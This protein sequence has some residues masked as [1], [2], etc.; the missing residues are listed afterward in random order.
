V[1]AIRR[2]VFEKV[3]GFDVSLKV[4]EDR[5]L[6]ITLAEGD[7]LGAVAN[8]ALI[9]VDEGVNSLSR[10]VTG[11]RGGAD[12][13]LRVIDKHLDYLRLPE[14]HEF[15]SEYLL[16]IFA[17]FLQAGN[18]RAAMHIVGELRQRGALDS[19]VFRNYLRHAPEFRALKRAIRYSTMRRIRN[20]LLS[21]VSVANEAA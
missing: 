12:S 5:D 15:L 19:R 9:D 10:S 17:G 6:F 4:S 7:Y 20:R 11:V 16:V 2:T 3:G 1:F 8:A 18:R 21:R 13:D 14:H